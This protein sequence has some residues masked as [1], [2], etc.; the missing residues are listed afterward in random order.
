MSGV[1]GGTSETPGTD[2]LATNR[3]IRGQSDPSGPAGPHRFIP[4]PRHGRTMA[5][6]FG[7]A[8]SGAT[9]DKA[10]PAHRS[11]RGRLR[12]RRSGLR[13]KLYP[14]IGG[15]GGP[16]Q[17]STRDSRDG[18]GLS[19]TSRY[20]SPLPGSVS[21]FSVCADPFAPAGSVAGRGALPSPAGRW[22]SFPVSR[23][24]GRSVVGVSLSRQ[25]RCGTGFDPA[26][27][28]LPGGAVPAKRPAS[29]EL[30][31]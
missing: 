4:P 25:K 9:A 21:V 18:R 10:F 15:P 19:S 20:C 8:P 2:T 29:G 31:S 11:R 26:P 30:T 7:P 13:A 1:S 23:L 27:A 14:R 3:D 12:R 6:A 22:F 28:C 16:A 5:H 24:L 17:R